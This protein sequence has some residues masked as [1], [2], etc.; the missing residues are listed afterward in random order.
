MFLSWQ[1]N[2]E[3]SALCRIG[4][5]I[6]FSC[7]IPGVFSMIIKTHVS[8]QSNTKFILIIKPTRCTNF[9]KFIFGI[10]LYMFRTVPLSIIGVFHCTH[11]NG[12]CHKSLLTACEQ[13]QDG[14]G[15]VLLQQNQ[16]SSVLTY[17]TAV[18]TVKNPLMMDRGTVRNM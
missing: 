2:I 4:L 16:T 18:C 9:S 3:Y 1:C 12:I 7:G 15:F 13:D 14:T 6:I 10:K 5:F 17:T 11:S 8:F